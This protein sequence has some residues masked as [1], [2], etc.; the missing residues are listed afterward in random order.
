MSKYLERKAKSGE[1]FQFTDPIRLPLAGQEIQ[2]ALVKDVLSSL[3]NGTEEMS[4]L[5]D[6]EIKL[7][8][9]SGD[10]GF[11]EVTKVLRQVTASHAGQEG[12]SI[13]L[14]LG[15]EMS[16]AFGNEHRLREVIDNIFS[17]AVRHGFEGGAA[18]HIEVEVLFVGEDSLQ[19]LIGNDGTPPTLP[20]GEMIKKGVRASASKGTGNGLYMA[21]RW[22]REMG[23][24]MFDATELLSSFRRPIT[25]AVGIE[26][27]QP[28]S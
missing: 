1:P 7:F 26:L 17:N 14:H 9:A 22:V 10:Q 28:V 13:H 20:F 15:E 21:D 8:R 3:V 2:P 12:Y 11:V 4:D 25:F 24:H 6:E 18:N 5:I 16:D 23:G 27:K 19:I